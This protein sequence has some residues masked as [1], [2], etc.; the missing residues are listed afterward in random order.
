MSHKSMVDVQEYLT[1]RLVIHGGTLVSVAESYPGIWSFK[2]M[3]GNS[4]AISIPAIHHY[5]S[6]F[7]IGLFIKEG[8]PTILI[9]EINERG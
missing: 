7:I 4:L 2:V 8:E 1:Y 6:I 5:N 9:L 3:P